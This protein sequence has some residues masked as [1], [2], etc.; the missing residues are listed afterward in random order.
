MNDDIPNIHISGD[1]QFEGQNIYGSKMDLVELRK[2]VGMV[3]QQ[4]SP[5]PFSVYDN[6]AYGQRLLELRIKS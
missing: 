1:I 4:P 5:F 2:E 3:F 6:I